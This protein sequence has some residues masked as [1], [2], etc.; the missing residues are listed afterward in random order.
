MVFS[1]KADFKIDKGC[2][3]L[4]VIVVDDEP[5]NLTL[6]GALI[7]KIE[8]CHPVCFSDPEIA[9][10][11]CMGN[12]VALAITDYSMP[13]LDGVEFVHRFLK[14]PGKEDVPVLMLT[15][16]AGVTVRFRALMAGAT[17]LMEKPFEAKRLTKWIE[18]FIVRHARVAN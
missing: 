2:S 13:E 7:G 6:I 8:G 17:E 14:L 1:S 18:K 10:E 15:G 11:W 16:T 3:N 4:N 12:E 5:L 9:L